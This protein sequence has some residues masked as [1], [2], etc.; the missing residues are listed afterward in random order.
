MKRLLLLVLFLIVFSDSEG[1][2]D[3]LLAKQMEFF[4]VYVRTMDNER[5]KTSVTGINDSGL[6]IT[7]ANGYS[8]HIPA[9]NIQ[10]LSLK[11]KKGVVL[12]A[13]VGFAFGAA[14]GI[15]AG[16]SDGDQPAYDGSTTDPVST[17][18]AGVSTYLAMTPKERSFAVGLALSGAL[19]GAITGALVKKKFSIGG[20]E[21]SF[22]NLE[23][24]M[25][26][27]LVQK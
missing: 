21:K 22:R 20:R 13:L 18:V 15:T 4:N 5:I 10:S 6:V 26:K 17:I 23:S 24:E 19:I 25:M 1:Q 14:T 7:N 8:S 12:G 27:K 11:R 2:L 16:I 9:E 3:S